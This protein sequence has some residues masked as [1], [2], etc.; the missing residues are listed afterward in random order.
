MTRPHARPKVK[1]ASRNPVISSSMDLLRSTYGAIATGARTIDVDESSGALID[2]DYPHV[3]FALR[4]TQGDILPAPQHI[5]VDPDLECA[6]ASTARIPCRCDS[7]RL[8]SSP[9]KCHIGEGRHARRKSLEPR[10]EIGRDA[11][12]HRSS[13]PRGHSGPRN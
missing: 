12:L 6:T 10:Y 8:R 3:H 5:A 4:A 7:C 1:S 2:A 9:R 13:Q 11:R